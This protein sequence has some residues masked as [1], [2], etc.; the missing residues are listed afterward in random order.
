M[1]KTEDLLRALAKL[2]SIDSK[3]DSLVKLR[4]SLP[5]EV[6]DLEDDIEGFET[7][8]NRIQE[9]IDALELEIAKRNNNIS[10]YSEEISKYET[11][12]ND[13]KNNREYEVLQKEIEYANLEILT[14]E[15]KIRQF[16]E[17]IEQKQVLLDETQRQIDERNADLEAK[18]KELE[19]IIEET[20]IEENKLQEESDIASEKVEARILNNYRNVRNNMRNGLAVVSTDREACG[21]C[22]AIVPPQVHLELRQKKKLIVCENCGRILVDQSFFDEVSDRESVG[23]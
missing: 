4:G 9:D 19:V 14:S 8:R 7:R 23:A 15:K 18:K 1:E 11:Q 3:L 13:V 2:Q 21:G 22:F 16:R 12:L 10:H 5:E 17:Q 6:A 20:R